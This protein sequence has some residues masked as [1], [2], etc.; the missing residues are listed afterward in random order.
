MDTENKYGT[1]E[2]QK[3]LL[4]LMKEFHLF[5]QKNGVVY[6][7]AAGSL[8]GAIRHNG[9]IP[10]DDDLDVFV[11][12]ENYNRIVQL[13]SSNDVLIVERDSIETLWVDRVRR[14]EELGKGQYIP[15][16]DLLVLD[17]VPNEKLKRKAKLFSIM[18]LQGMMKPHVNLKKGSL[19]FRFA[20]FIT[21]CV[22]KLF[23]NRWKKQWYRK[24][25]QIGNGRESNFIS[26]YNGAFADIGRLYPSNMMNQ[27]ELH[28]FEDTEVCIVSAWDT[29][30]K[31]HFGDY[32]TPP[33]EADRRPL[34]GGKC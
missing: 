17:H 20:S 22:G 30:L 28:P 12:R 6:S 15:T 32:M 9:F 23:P 8:L 2:S 19:P 3:R 4:N 14:K 1:L 25:S 33:K 13:L 26:N 10:W 29:C 34:H 16:L 24:I 31:T 7:M 21:M 5:C 27:I 18:C 11:D